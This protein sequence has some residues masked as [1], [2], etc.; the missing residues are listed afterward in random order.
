MMVLRD[1]TSHNCACWVIC[2]RWRYI[3]NNK[4][5]K[6]Q[7][8]PKLMLTSS[9]LQASLI[10]CCCCCCCD[11]TGSNLC[12]PLSCFILSYWSQCA[13]VG[14]VRIAAATGM[15]RRCGGN[16]GHVAKSDR[17]GLRRGRLMMLMW[18]ILSSSLSLMVD[19]QMK[20]SPETWVTLGIE[21]PKSYT[22]QWTQTVPENPHRKQRAGIWQHLSF[23][24]AQVKVI[25]SPVISGYSPVDTCNQCPACGPTFDRLISGVLLGLYGHLWGVKTFKKLF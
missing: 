25:T 17:S 20:I 1:K 11:L 4:F 5:V 16:V 2:F 6:Y 22:S 7:T 19:G 14:R 18:I 8:I 24:L 21:N 9:K 10:V 15:N 23:R 3:K 13:T 12:F